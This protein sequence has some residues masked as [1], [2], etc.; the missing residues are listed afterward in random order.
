MSRVQ[1]TAKILLIALATLYLTASAA[2]EVL[3]RRLERMGV[4]FNDDWSFVKRSVL[5]TPP[6]QVMLLDTATIPM[7]RSLRWVPGFEEMN[8]I[9]KLKIDPDFFSELGIQKKVHTITIVS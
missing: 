2:R 4:E 8:T 1:S 3:I 7:A 6:Q 5:W 9:S